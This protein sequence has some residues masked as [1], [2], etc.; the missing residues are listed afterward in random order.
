MHMDERVKLDP[1]PVRLGETLKIKYNGLLKSSGAQEIYLHYGHDGWKEPNA[2]MMYQLPEG[3]FTAEITAKACQEINFCFKDR[4]EN[5]DN[6]SGY[7]WKCDV[8]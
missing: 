4:V 8:I 2:V 6:N 3:D 7:N 5:W 1:Q